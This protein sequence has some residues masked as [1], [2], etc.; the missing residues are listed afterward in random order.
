MDLLGILRTLRRHWVLIV[1]LAVA[2]ALLGAASSQLSSSSSAAKSRTYYKATNTMVVDFSSR[3]SQV[4][5]AFSGLDQLALYAVTGD[6]P[7]TVAKKL[8]SEL[9][10]PELAQYITTSTDGSSS[11]I[12]I[13]AIDKEGSHAELLADTW[14]NVLAS[15]LDDRGTKNYEQARDSIQ[16]RLDALQDT[17]NSLLGQLAV[18]PRIANYDNV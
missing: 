9:S 12:K 4:P 6:V 16:Q 17:E 1:S 14:A 3:S 2:G 15:N 8:G 13:T 18:Q 10:G 11:T 5:P 7:A